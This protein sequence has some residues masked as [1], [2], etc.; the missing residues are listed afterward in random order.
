MKQEKWVAMIQCSIFCQMLQKCSAKMAVQWKESRV[1]SAFL[2]PPSWEREVG[3]QSVFYGI[4]R[5]MQAVLS[6]IYDKLKLDTLFGDSIFRH[7]YLWAVL[8][9]V[10][11]PLLPTMGVLALAL[12]ASLSLLLN[13]VRDRERSLVYA[14]MNRYVWF[15]GLF[16]LALTFVSVTPT[17]SLLVGLVTVV[18]VCFAVV[19]QNA[20]ETQ[21]EFRILLGFFVLA[22]AVVALIG[23]YQYIFRTGYQSAAWVDSDMFTSIEFRVPSTLDNP[24]MLGQYFILTIPFT[25]ACLLSAKTWEF[26]ILWFG[27]AA[28][29]VIC[30]ILTFSRGAWLGLLVAGACFFL[31][32]NP[33]F[34]YLIPVAL[35]GLYF[36]LP[37][38]VIERFTSIGDMED[39]STSYRVYIWMGTFAML[40]EYWISGVGAGDAAFN[41]VYPLYSYNSIVA[42]HS[43]NLFLQIICD[44]GFFLLV[45]FC[46]FLFHYFR[47]LCVSLK[48]SESWEGKLF[49]IA[50]ISSIGGFLVQAMTDYSFYNYRVLFLFWVAVGLGGLA[51]SYDKL[52][53]ESPRGET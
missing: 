37:A 12:V 32:M 17:A 22:G 6:A 47:G 36:V 20:V 2:S 18:F 35:I 21:K 33:K 16:Y 1:I 3:K 11:A 15:Y 25:G 34:A 53:K 4:W 31:L 13:L 26:R 10:L 44:G 38:S 45:I 49:Q 43:H 50:G 5:K 39:A 46:L 27:C 42:P 41:M 29:Q 48:H 40:K 28:L 19:L 52:P 23:M 7:S 30:M 24:N 51:M 9:A 14:P 8:V